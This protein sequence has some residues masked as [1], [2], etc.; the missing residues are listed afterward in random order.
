[1]MTAKSSCATIL[2]LSPRSLP[3]RPAYPNNTSHGS[4]FQPELLLLFFLSD[5]LVI[6][7]SHKRGTIGIDHH[8]LSLVE[9]VCAVHIGEPFGN[10]LFDMHLAAVRFLPGCLP[11]NLTILQPFPYVLR[12]WPVVLIEWGIRIS[13]I[14]IWVSPVEWQPKI[15]FRLFIPGNNTSLLYS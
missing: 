11:G 8:E 12:R 14:R 7:R 4:R 9:G 10:A 15:R 1:M 5:N 3:Q 13:R 6:V 2:Q